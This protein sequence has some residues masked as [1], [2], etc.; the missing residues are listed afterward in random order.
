MP[1]PTFT[2]PDDRGFFEFCVANA[3]TTL[4]F[5]RN[6]DGEVQLMPPS[7]SETGKANGYVLVELS[8][9]NRMNGEPGYVFDASSGFKFPNGAIRAPDVAY[10]EKSRYDVLPLSERELH[11]PVAPDFV[12]EVMP[13][14]ERLPRVRAKTEEYKTNRVRLGWLIDRK[15]RTVYVYRPDMAAE[16]L[17]APTTVAADPELPGFVLSLDRVF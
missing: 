7:G 2:L 17:P 16:T 1:S 6:A 13:P 10:V 12:V 9:W 11:A 8:L 3:D 15:N 14:C 4:P 5:E